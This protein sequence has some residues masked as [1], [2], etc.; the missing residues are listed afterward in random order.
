MKGIFEKWGGF[1][2]AVSLKEEGAT[3]L[4]STT[5]KIISFSQERLQKKEEI[6][7][8]WPLR[9]QNMLGERSKLTKIPSQA[10]TLKKY[11][12]RIR[13]LETWFDK[14]TSQNSLSSLI[15]P[16]SSEDEKH[17]G[18]S[19]PT[20][21]EVETFKQQAYR[22]LY[23]SELYFSHPFLGQKEEGRKIVSHHPVSLKLETVLSDEEEQFLSG[24]EAEEGTLKLSNEVER[25]L[26]K[27]GAKE[28][29]IKQTWR[30]FSTGFTP[31]FFSSMVV[32]QTNW[33]KEEDVIVKTPTIWSCFSPKMVRRRCFLCFFQDKITLEFKLFLEI[34]SIKDNNTDRYPLIFID[35]RHT[36][37]CSGKTWESSASFCLQPKPLSVFPPVNPKQLFAVKVDAMF[38]RKKDF[39]DYWLFLYK[40]R[41][42]PPEN[43]EEIPGYALTLEQYHQRLNRWIEKK[44][45]ISLLF[46]SKD[47][48]EKEEDA[49]AQVAKEYGRCW[50][51]I[52]QPSPGG[53]LSFSK[54]VD[55]EAENPED[56][57][58]QI[59][60]YLEK[61]SVK[62]EVI[63]QTWAFLSQ[64]GTASAT[65]AM[66]FFFYSYL[67]KQDRQTE[68]F[69][70][71]NVGGFTKESKHYS[72]VVPRFVLGAY[73]GK[74]SIKIDVTQELFVADFEKEG[75]RDKLE[76]PLIRTMI[77]H[78]YFEEL[79]WQQSACFYVDRP[80]SRFPSSTQQLF[81]CYDGWPREEK[82]RKKDVY[83]LG[84]SVRSFKK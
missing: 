1:T 24:R 63:K 42:Y 43:Q 64:A 48:E 61:N 12:K 13:K 11:K 59:R 39:F 30:M 34:F 7:Q 67:Y 60:T 37:Y 77:Q 73:R 47:Q 38:E 9:N 66:S 69:R 62:T 72:L 68:E 75:A 83:R 15:L 80:G 79:G 49:I 29:A 53:S 70:V 22:N 5:D 27:Q 6:L 76:N 65:M 55:L 10:L 78:D 52:Y 44:E 4:I 23:N 19:I 3:S 14:K 17:P 21:K 41:Q 84:N 8:D 16:L 33:D 40:Q 28:D 51:Q 20:K 35:L 2:P 36:Y 74:I 46:D 71:K 58:T 31:A 54:F 81:S 26:W 57:T 18:V 50:F 82:K 32:F 56:L 45:C 25:F